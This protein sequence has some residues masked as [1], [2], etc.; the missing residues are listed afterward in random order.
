MCVSQFY[1]AFDHLPEP[2][3][4]AGQ[5]HFDFEFSLSGQLLEL[6]SAG[7]ANTAIPHRLIYKLT[8]ATTAAEMAAAAATPARPHQDRKCSG[9]LCEHLRWSWHLRDFAPQCFDT[10]A[11][12][13][14][15][16]ATT[17]FFDVC[18]ATSFGPYCGSYHRM[19][20]TMITRATAASLTRSALQGRRSDG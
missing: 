1:L 16:G 11:A 14:V 17:F 15:E 5:D 7:H 18:D 19:S 3:T 6:T 8:R 10:E 2:R 13:G 9:F 4:L 20:P 12:I